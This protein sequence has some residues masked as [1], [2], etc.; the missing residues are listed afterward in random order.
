MWVV[1][2]FLLCTTSAQPFLHFD[3]KCFF[4]DPRTA[5]IAAVKSYPDCKMSL[6][7][8]FF[9][10]VY[11]IFHSIPFSYLCNC[12]T[13][14]TKHV[15]VT[16]PALCGWLW[17]RETLRKKVGGYNQGLIT[18]LASESTLAVLAEDISHD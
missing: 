8:L 7:N 9:P 6:E 17:A 18:F 2:S 14:D 13:T 4:L 3:N 1:S 11:D 15:S 12:L 16:S 10:T 5:R